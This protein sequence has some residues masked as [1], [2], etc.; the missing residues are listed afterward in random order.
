MFISNQL[1][2]LKRTV[3]ATILFSI[4]GFTHIAWSNDKTSTAPIIILGD[5]ISAA[6]GISLEQGW[7]S[8][9]SQY[10]E[11]HYHQKNYHVINASISGE[12]TDGAL[13]R[14]PK[15]LAQYQPTIVIIELGGNDGLRGYPIPNFRNNL[16]Q[17]VSLVKDTNAKVLLTGMQIPPNYG[18]RYTQMFYESYGIIA[19]KYQIPLVSFLLDEIAIYPELMQRDGIHPKASAQSKILQNVLP[20]LKEIL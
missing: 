17:M 12:T 14:L 13:S 1:I 3:F 8:L 11:K 10:L 19:H 18:S 5:S 7:V 4:L 2:N 20:E 15:L 6:Y 16:G 9:L